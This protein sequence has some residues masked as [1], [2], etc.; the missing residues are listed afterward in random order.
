MTDTDTHPSMDASRIGQL[1][2]TERPISP[3]QDQVLIELEP[4]VAMSGLLHIPETANRKARCR[5]ARVIAVGPGAF[6]KRGQRIP[7]D[8]SA[9]DRVL[10]KGDPGWVIGPYRMVRQ[11]AIEA[12]LEEGVVV[13]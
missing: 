9:G 6:D 3:L 7:M 13:E 1:S 10:V 12:P 11:G 5:A 4:L 8:Y 2:F